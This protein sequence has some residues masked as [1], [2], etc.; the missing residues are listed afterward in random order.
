[1]IGRYL[2]VAAAALEILAGAILI[3]ALDFA[4]RLLFATAP[5]GV[6]I[7]LG[8]WVGIGLVALGIAC[9]PSGKGPRRSVV[10]GLLTYNAGFLIMAVWLGLATTFRGWLLWPAAVLHA[11]IAASLLAQLV[12][13][14]SFFSEQSK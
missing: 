13:K 8:R 3:T 1:M 14:D 7:P 4:C 2:I 11:T 12:T 10:L 5:E 6:G 9:L